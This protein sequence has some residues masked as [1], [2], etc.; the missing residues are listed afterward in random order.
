MSQK[1]DN[2]REAGR[3]T[4][5]ENIDNPVPLGDNHLL[6]IGIDQYKDKTIPNL[7]N[8]VRD[9]D[10]ITNLLTQQ[11][12]FSTDSTVKIL[13][14]DATQNNI[15]EALLSLTQKAKDQ[16]RVL[17][18]FSGHGEFNEILDIGYWVPTDGELGKIGSYISFQ[19]IKQVIAAIKSHHT[20]IISDSCYSGSFFADRSL[21]KLQNKL[22]RKPSRWILTAGRNEVVSD[23][24]VG[25][26]SPFADSVLWHLR[27]NKAPR[28]SVADFCQDIIN[29]VGKNHEQLPRGSFIKGVGD[30]GGQFMFRL[31]AYA[32]HV[33]DEDIAEIQETN[34]RTT[35]EEPQEEHVPTTTRTTEPKK[36]EPE[37]PLTSLADVKERLKKY[38]S[39]DDFEAA[40]DL[41]HE[42]LD[43]SNSR[44]ENK[45]I[46]QQGRFNANEDDLEDG[47]AS[48][49]EYNR[50]K[51]Q[52]RKAVLNGLVKD[53]E[54][55]DIKPDFFKNASTST[56]DNTAVQLDETERK[57][58]VKQ[59]DLLQQKINMFS[60]Q[61]VIISDVAQKFTLKKQLE[62]AKEELA[63]IK[64]KLGI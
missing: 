13:N 42:V 25:G 4:G 15:I 61:L 47:T 5:N 27:D 12:Q 20:F 28:L 59:A 63:E 44:M 29:D 64:S 55:D 43:P 52:I 45:L 39:R 54:E 18:Y 17:I 21:N 26:N 34:K 3:S 38:L 10:D 58:L 48:K 9:A 37:K 50:T 56:T 23:G 40:F 36:V 49:S 53:L 14:T 8:A 30:R 35:R 32:D 51:A 22:E 11:Y 19:L 16:D 33:F 46:M 24:R 41:L 6:V 7:A 62:A 57:G 1:S 2:T 31:K 60:E